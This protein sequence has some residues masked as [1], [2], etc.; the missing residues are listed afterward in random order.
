ITMPRKARKGMKVTIKYEGPIP[1]P[2]K[3]GTPIASLEITAPDEKTIIVPLLAGAD[4]GALGL[5]GR[6][7]A[8]IDFLL[9]GE[10]GNI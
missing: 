6:L 5:V 9:W 2:I 3:A 4:V 8:A 7:G 1:A 10:S